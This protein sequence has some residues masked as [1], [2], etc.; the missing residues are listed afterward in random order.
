M[1]QRT[2]VSAVIVSTQKKVRINLLR[3]INHQAIAVA[4][5]DGELVAVVAVQEHEEHVARQK[6]RPKH[7]LLALTQRRL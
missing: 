7:L 3:L 2:I 6:G 1:G 5:D 4:S